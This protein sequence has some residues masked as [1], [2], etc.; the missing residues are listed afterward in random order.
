M[1]PIVSVNSAHRAVASRRAPLSS[2]IAR[3]RCLLT[4]T[5]IALVVISPLKLTLLE[6]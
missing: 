5:Q 2:G 3:S 4:P 6:G 1:A